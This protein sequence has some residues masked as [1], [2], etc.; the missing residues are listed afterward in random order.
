MIGFDSL[1][2]HEKYVC[3]VADEMKLEGLVF[4]KKDGDLIG[5]TNLGNVNEMLDRK[6]KNETPNKEIATSMFVLMV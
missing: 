4:N 2:T 5:F 6:E 1:Q 3:I